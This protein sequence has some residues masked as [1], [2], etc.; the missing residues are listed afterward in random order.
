MMRLKSLLLAVSLAVTAAIM[1]QASGAVSSADILVSVAPENPSPQETVII[2]LKSYLAN[3]DSVSISWTV[4]G[5]T[6]AV[7]VGKKTFSV[8]APDAGAEVRV[9]ATIALPDGNI[10]KAVVLRPAVMAL[11]WQAN[12]AYVPPFYKGKALPTADSQIKIVALPEIKSGSQMV[13]PKNM[14]YAWKK[15]YTNNPDG[16]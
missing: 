6:S 16:S 14:T 12:N 1:P 10:E 9:S 5:K 2:T 11:L 8:T 7:G 15:D 3:L 4:N 13:S